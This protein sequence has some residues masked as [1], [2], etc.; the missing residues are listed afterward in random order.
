MNPDRSSQHKIITVVLVLVILTAIGS[1]VYH[2]RSPTVVVNRDLAV[3][4]GQ[5]VATETVKLLHDRG[6][7]GVIITPYHEM[8]GLREYDTWQAFK[9]ALQQHPQIQ[10]VETEIANTEPPIEYGLTRTRLDKILTAHPELDGVVSF[11]GIAQWDP[12][13][14]FELPRN[15]L[16][17]IAVQNGSFAIKPYFAKGS[18]AVAIV[19]REIPAPNSAMP[20]TPADWFTQN[21]QVFTVENY[22]SLPDEEAPQ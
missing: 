7:M 12:R 15:D 11:Y 4:L 1:V 6:R 2:F 19:R 17:I 13:A 22:Q 8:E 5:A 18:L 16:K 21:Y 9:A 14:P 3:G 20:R 10:I